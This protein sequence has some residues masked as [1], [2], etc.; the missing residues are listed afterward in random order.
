MNGFYNGF[1]YV[2]IETPEERELKR[3]KQKKLFS[4]VF[5]ALFLYLLVSQ[6]LSIGIYAFAPIILNKEQYQAF[7]Q[8]PVW[9][10]VISCVVQYAI[11]FPIFLLT[12]IG[13]DT[14]QSKEKSKLSFK[15]FIL[16]FFI[17]E[18]LMYVGNL[19]G[20]FLNQ[21]I[22]TMIGRV[23]ENGIA[24]IISETPIWLIFIFMVIV[25]PIVEE[26]IC[27]KLIIDRLSI[28]G[29][30]IAILFSA[31]AFGLLHGNLYQFFYAALLGALL[32][33][34]YTK[35]RNIRYTIYMHM[36]I[37][38]MGSIVALPVENA[39]N[40]FYK[41][42]EL[43]SLGEPFNV[44]SLLLNGSIML[45]Y[46]NLQYG[47]IIGGI[48]ALIYLLKK[49]QFKIKTDKEIYLPNAEVIKSGFVNVGSILFISLCIIFMII[50]LFT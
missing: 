6:L 26:L 14:A 25:A 19:I 17:G 33:Y 16:L 12:L 18:A 42:F 24:T 23:P 45:L 50:N 35:T 7:V 34:V 40:E 5:L 29:D 1:D 48:F 10:V 27:R 9:S 46:T 20:T 21:T 38:F 15:D 11:A 37:N 43:A 4:R 36:I 22:G 28:Y 49:G 3:K 41:I 32:G 47:M 30:H 31:V 13:T 8:S 2:V 44:F 39:M